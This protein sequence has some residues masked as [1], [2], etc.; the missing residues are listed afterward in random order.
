[1]A[2]VC[3]TLFYTGCGGGCGAVRCEPLFFLYG[4]DPV[5]RLSVRSG[6]I[7]LPLSTR[8]GGVAARTM[9]TGFCVA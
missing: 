2:A 4:M 7:G 6:L 8:I 5:S 1:M 9:G 3:L